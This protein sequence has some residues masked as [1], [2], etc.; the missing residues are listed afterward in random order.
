MNVYYKYIII[1]YMYLYIYIYI[2]LIMLIS[3]VLY[4]LLINEID[5]NKSNQKGGDIDFKTNKFVFNLEDKK[6]D[7]YKPQRFNKNKY[8]SV[9]KKV[10]K[11]AEIEPPIFYTERDYAEYKENDYNYYENELLNTMLPKLSHTYSI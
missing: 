4:Y 6:L 10:D 11:P 7:K 5:I 1:I 2:I 8:H 9:S 3:N